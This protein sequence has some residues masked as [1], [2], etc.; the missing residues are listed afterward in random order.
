[1]F[2]ETNLSFGYQYNSF[3]LSDKRGLQN[4]TIS[5]LY[6][7]ILIDRT[8]SFY[9]RSLSLTIIFKIKIA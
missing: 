1:M 5:N 3:Q 9:T 2:H 7:I 6:F 8:D 4:F